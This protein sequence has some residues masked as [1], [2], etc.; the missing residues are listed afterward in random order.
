METRSEEMFR[1]FCRRVGWW[2]WRVRTRDTAELR[3]PDFVVWRWFRRVAVEV[4]QINPNPDDVEQN[5]RMDAGLIATFGGEPGA[6]LRDAIKDASSQLKSMTRA[7]WPG[8]VVLYDNTGLSNYVDGYHIK[9]AMYGLE[10]VVLQRTGRTSP[11]SE[12][13]DTRFGPRR[14]MTET[15]GT[16]AYD[17]D[18]R[19]RCERCVSVAA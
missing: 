9:T 13:V 16:A 12:I 3:R 4:K 10:M 17:R 8:L 5:S 11:M 15:T 2:P 18:H 1:I 7:R 6:R 14:R 19:Y